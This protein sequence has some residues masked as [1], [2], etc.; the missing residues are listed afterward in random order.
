MTSTDTSST[1]AGAPRKPRLA[2]MGEFS[3]GKSTLTNL[4]LG[5]RPLPEQVTATR[6]APV[7]IS[8][9][10]DAPYRQRLNGVQEPITLELLGQVPVEDTHSIRMFFEADVLDLCDIIDIPGIS[11]PN[12]D[13]EVWQR[14]VQDI[15]VVL[16]CTHAT[17][18][19]RQS[20]AAAW[21]TIPLAVQQRSALLL[22]RFDKLSNER[23][24]G[25]VLARISHETKDQF[26]QVFP[27]K[28][29]QALNA[30]DDVD[31]WEDSGAAAL[32]DHLGA[33][34]ANFGLNDSAAIAPGGD[35]NVV[36]LK[37]PA[38]RSSIVDIQPQREGEAGGE[39]IATRRIVPRRIKT[40]TP[41]SRPRPA[42]P[43]RGA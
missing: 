7:W 28:L 36:T 5:Q 26:A 31:A 35:A 16:W 3:S 37:T 17:Q 15:D 41:T 2:I 12:M 43:P 14:M 27:M 38:T 34:L 11:D 39:K 18:A 32:L 21:A 9:G 22:T 29:L 8:K 33:V 23:D 19:W 13:A 4:F 40:D 25:R 30:G 42:R 6:L 20:E 1:D 24:R 10:T